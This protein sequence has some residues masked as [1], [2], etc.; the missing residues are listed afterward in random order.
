MTER[1]TTA[2]KRN[3]VFY[4]FIISA[5]QREQVCGE[6]DIHICMECD[7]P[8]DKINKIHR[9]IHSNIKCDCWG[10]EEIYK[11]N[12]ICIKC[13]EGID[14]NSTQ[15]KHFKRCECE[16]ITEGFR[17]V[18]EYENHNRKIIELPYRTE[19]IFYHNKMEWEIINYHDGDS[20]W[21]FDCFTDDLDYRDFTDFINS[22]NKT[23]IKLF[24][25]KI[26][27]MPYDSFI[28]EYFAH[29]KINDSYFI[30]HNIKEIVGYSE[31][32]LK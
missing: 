14:Y 17:Y 22:K 5:Y 7:K 18:I 2:E 32:S 3:K 31:F 20:D 27:Y 23:T 24:S 9:D 26:F 25:N 28:N 12:I 11:P 8:I 13:N 6:I 21:W 19:R 30:S 29:K 4:E 16:E 1:M 15:F 10:E